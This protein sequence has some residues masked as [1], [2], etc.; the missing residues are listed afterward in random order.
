MIIKGDISAL[1]QARMDQFIGD[2]SHLSPEEAEA[3][4]KHVM[5][6]YE[7][8]VIYGACLDP[9]SLEWKSNAQ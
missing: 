9:K 7:R 6:K 5:E 3:V 4:R 8:N 1:N 2:L